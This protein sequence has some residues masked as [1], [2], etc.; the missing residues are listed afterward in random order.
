MNNSMNNGDDKQP[1][2]NVQ[3]EFFNIP[4]CGNFDVLELGRPGG[5]LLATLVHRANEKGLQLKEMA[6][7]LGVTHGYINQ[8]RNGIRPVKQISNAFALACAEFLGISR[9]S[10]LMLVEIVTTADFFESEEMMAAE[11]SRAIG[12]ICDDMKWG[13]LVTPEIREAD[14]MSQFGVV[15][16]YEE[17]T[18]KVLLDKALNWQSLAIEITKLKTVYA[19]QEVAVYERAMKKRGCRKLKKQQ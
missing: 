18:G 14:E 8:L 3:P 7:A 4:G 9:M 10:V 11:I 15:K 13:H 1:D 6:K 12:F 16:L 2:G 5:L 19:R 17:A